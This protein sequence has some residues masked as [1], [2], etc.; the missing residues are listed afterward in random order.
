MPE[1][2]LKA[3]IR[4]KKGKSAAKASRHSGFIPAVVYAPGKEAQAL[5]LSRHDFLRFIHQHHVEST[6]VNLKISS[7]DSRA[8]IVKEVQYHPVKED[9]IH[10]DFQQISL[11]AKIKVS[12]G[13]KAKGE[14]LGVKQ[15]G[16]TLNHIIWELEIECL[17]TQIPPEIEVDVSAL[18]IGDTVCIKDLNLPEAVKAI[19]DP[20]SIV[21]SL[22]APRKEEEPQ[23]E[24]GEGEGAMPEP[25]VIKEKKEAP[26]ESAKAKEKEKEE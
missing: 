9:I 19:G 21:F 16:G 8:V 22:E 15:E 4:E 1:V 14:P 20:D 11:T 12:V 18:K 23:P 7:A 2:I 17:P 13:V 3:K 26:G 5:E 24:A 25:E 6:L 10:I